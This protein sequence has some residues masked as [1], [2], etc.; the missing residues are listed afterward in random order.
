MKKDKRHYKTAKLFLS[1]LKLPGA[2]N[3]Y[4]RL[5]VGLV[6]DSIIYLYFWCVKYRNRIGRLKKQVQQLNKKVKELEN[7][8]NINESI[9]S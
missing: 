5:H 6:K 9:I 7:G 1:S 4:N 3:F 2:N 8:N